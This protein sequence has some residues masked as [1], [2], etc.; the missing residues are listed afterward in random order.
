M[1]VHSEARWHPTHLRVLAYLTND[2]FLD[3]VLFWYS[4]DRYRHLEGRASS[5]RHAP[6]ECALPYSRGSQRS[7]CTD[8]GTSD[9]CWPAYAAP[10][11]PSCRG[12]PRAV[13]AERDVVR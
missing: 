13:E 6:L 10:G 11:R 4:H 7:A 2:H 12:V 8:W 1:R 9:P 5:R 3:W